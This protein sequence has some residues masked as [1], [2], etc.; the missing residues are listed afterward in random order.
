[1]FSNGLS[2]VLGRSLLFFS[3]PRFLK[4]TEPHS[5]VALKPWRTIYQNGNSKILTSTL[6]TTG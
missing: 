3:G 5:D 2:S 6:E 1:M 4:L